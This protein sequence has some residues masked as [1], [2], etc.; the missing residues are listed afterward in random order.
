MCVHRADLLQK[1]GTVRNDHK[2]YPISELINIFRYMDTCVK[3]ECKKTPTEG[4]E[5][6][7]FY[8]GFAMTALSMLITCFFFRKKMI[9]KLSDFVDYLRNGRR[10]RFP[11]RQDET[12]VRSGAVSRTEFTPIMG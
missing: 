1:G 11:P 7:L 6:T 8:I 2:N 9:E 5:G 10:V 3:L 12:D 4:I